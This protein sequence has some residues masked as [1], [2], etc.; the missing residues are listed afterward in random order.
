MSYYRF[1]D[2][3]VYMYSSLSLKIAKRVS[4]GKI[5][6]CACR[7]NHKDKWGQYP[8]TILN[9]NKE[10]LKHLKEH[11]YAGHKVPKDAIDKL[12]EEIKNEL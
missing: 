6:C 4:T 10:A 5:V 2:G 7:L 11:I 3:D 1:S 9:T 12:K 8:D